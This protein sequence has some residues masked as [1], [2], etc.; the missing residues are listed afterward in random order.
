MEMDEKTIEKIVRMTVAEL[1]AVD[2]L[3]EPGKSDYQ[4]TE[5]LL[6]NY[7][8][9]IASRNPDLLEI[10]KKVDYALEAISSDPYYSVIIMYYMSGETRESIAR[11]FDTSERT[12]SRQKGR[13][14]NLLSEI[15]FPKRT[16]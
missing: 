2:M 15:I 13:L 4:K 8:Y 3:S 5:D 12:I 14:V 10:I 6:R 11:T 7:N 16:G 9:F 1:K